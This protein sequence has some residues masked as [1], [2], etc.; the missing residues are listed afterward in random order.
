MWWNEKV[1]LFEK[2]KQRTKAQS[3][4]K[5]E[6]KMFDQIH[7]KTEKNEQKI[8]IEM[9]WNESWYFKILKQKSET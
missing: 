8:R 2:W 4:L 6:N 1:K 3:N 7:K 9:P 5:V